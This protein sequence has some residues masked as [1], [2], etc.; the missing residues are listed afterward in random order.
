[1]NTN[2]LIGRSVCMLAADLLG[3][4][5]NAVIRLIDTNSR[6][7]LLEFVSPIQINEQTYRFAVARPRLQRDDLDMLLKN[8]SV[9][10][11]VTCVSGDHYDSAKPFDLGWWRGG[12]AVIADLV[13]I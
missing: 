8:G 10:C 5:V 3:T 12:G 9:G 13:L 4:S 7:L 1:M 11:G 6:S 2:Q